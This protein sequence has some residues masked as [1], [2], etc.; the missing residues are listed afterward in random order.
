[1]TLKPILTT[2]GQRAMQ[3]LN[4]DFGYLFVE[5][6]TQNGELCSV[7]YPEIL[8]PFF[9]GLANYRLRYWLTIRLLTELIHL[10]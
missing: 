2:F 10:R 7:K 3:K 9:V 8:N 4:T 1:M 5:E 6:K